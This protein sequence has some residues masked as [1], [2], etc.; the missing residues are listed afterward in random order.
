MSSNVMPGRMRDTLEV[1]SPGEGSDEWGV[2]NEGTVLGKI[3]GN[4]VVRS[5]DQ[6]VNFGAEIDSE[7]ITILTYNRDYLTSKNLIKW[8]HRGQDK[9]YEVKHVKPADNRHKS[10]II[11]AELKKHD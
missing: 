5:G 4:V 2:P 7:V 1:I 11:T 6:N 3:R 10:M 8:L 9:M